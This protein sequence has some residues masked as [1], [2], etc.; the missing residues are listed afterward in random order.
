MF[1]S[2]NEVAKS[3]GDESTLVIGGI[4]IND[5]VGN[6]ISGMLRS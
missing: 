6:G 1:G 2:S 3:L 4:S 5:V